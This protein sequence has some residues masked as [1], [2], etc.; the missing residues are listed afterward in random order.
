MGMWLPWSVVRRVFVEVMFVVIV[1]VFVLHRLMNVPMFM[2]FGD[3]KP[4]SDQHKKA[5]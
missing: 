3:V 1:K 5:R 2:V 4:D